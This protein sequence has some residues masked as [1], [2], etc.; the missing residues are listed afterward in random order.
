[1]DL[2]MWLMTKSNKVVAD[3]PGWRVH[4]A[5]HADSTQGVLTGFN[6]ERSCR[7]THAL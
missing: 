7:E 3:M 4:R 1:M 2:K 5:R 6:Q